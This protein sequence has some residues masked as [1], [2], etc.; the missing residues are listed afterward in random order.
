MHMHQFPAQYCNGGDPIASYGNTS[1]TGWYPSTAND[2]R[3]AQSSP[4]R[5]AVPVLVKDG[6]P[7]SG[8]GGENQSSNSQRTNQ[9]HQGMTSSGHCN[10]PV[11]SQQMQ[12]CNTLMASYQRPSSMQH[13]HQQ[14]ANMC[15]SYLP[16]QGRAW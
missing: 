11:S 7:C 15:T 13:H 4:R 6:K 2:P 10:S 14:Q 12:Q 16:L 9:S 5:V 8:T 1:A 3:F